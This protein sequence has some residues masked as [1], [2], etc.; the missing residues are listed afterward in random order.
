MNVITSSP[1]VH[2]GRGIQL[3]IHQ[4]I[5]FLRFNDATDNMNEE[6]LLESD[7]KPEHVNDL[8]EIPS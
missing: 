8:N 5:L 7:C 4:A 2:V 3:G 1:V 6:R